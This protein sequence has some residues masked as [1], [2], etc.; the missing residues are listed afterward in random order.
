[1]FDNH[2]LRYSPLRDAIEAILSRRV[3][4]QRLYGY[5]LET[6]LEIAELVVK[7]CVDAH[8]LPE[9]CVAQR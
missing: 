2:P 1:M 6:S 9:R 8:F 5:T 3:F 7:G 4:E